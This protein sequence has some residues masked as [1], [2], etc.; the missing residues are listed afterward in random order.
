M[1]TDPRNGSRRDRSGFVEASDPQLHLM[2]INRRP[3]QDRPF[4]SR[5]DGIDDWRYGIDL[6]E[7][8]YL[9]TGLHERRLYDVTR[10]FKL[11]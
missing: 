10:V 1:K 2:P 8:V 3:R 9:V 11:I 7:D 5:F 6:G 4:H